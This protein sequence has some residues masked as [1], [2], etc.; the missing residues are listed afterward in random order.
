MI[1]VQGSWLDQ[2]THVLP[3]LA[4]AGAFD[5]I[6]R[7]GWRLP[8][9]GIAKL[10]QQGLVPITISDTGP[11]ATGGMLE[12]FKQWKRMGT[13]RDINDLDMKIIDGSAVFFIS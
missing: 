2:S 4:A 11:K 12:T 1:N 7:R 8:F 9:L 5:G 13:W 10:W 3:T 6:Y